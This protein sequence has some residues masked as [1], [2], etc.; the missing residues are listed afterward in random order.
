MVTT[1][2]FDYMKKLQNNIVKTFNTTFS[3]SFKKPMT[4]IS[5]SAKE[6][7]INIKL[8]GMAKKNIILEIY[9][10]KVEITAEKTKTKTKKTKKTYSKR[11]SYRGFHR[12]IPLPPNLNIDKADSVFKHNILTIKI[13]KT[14]IK[15]RKSIKVAT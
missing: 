3:D 12:I 4:D 5:Q 10:N 13:P 8:P 11:T 6:V 9:K 7:T 15:K 14:K 1:N 2:V